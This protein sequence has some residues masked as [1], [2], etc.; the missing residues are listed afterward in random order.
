MLWPFFRV[1]SNDTDND[2]EIHRV[3]R[4]I[5]CF[6]LDLLAFFV[7]VSAIPVLIVPYMQYINGKD[8][9]SVSDLKHIEIVKIAGALLLCSLSWWEN[10]I[11]DKVSWCKMSRI[12]QAFF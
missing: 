3:I 1:F 7:Q 9:N 10:F 2:K 4:T 8:T 6:V 12:K 5:F 11:D